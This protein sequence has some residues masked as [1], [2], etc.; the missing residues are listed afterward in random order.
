MQR[1]ESWFLVKFSR[2]N[3]QF[4]GSRGLLNH[5]WI[6]SANLSGIIKV[7]KLHLVRYA[8]CLKY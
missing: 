1:K 4:F 2:L 8:V 7:I 3:Y 5:I 6:G